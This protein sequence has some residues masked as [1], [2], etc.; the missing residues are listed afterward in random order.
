MPFAIGTQAD[1]AYAALPAG[2]TKQGPVFGLTPFTQTFN[3][4]VV[5]YMPI[6]SGIVGPVVYRANDDKSAWAPAGRRNSAL[7]R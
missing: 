7:Q 4:K 2:V 3:N 6:P 1:G 5:I